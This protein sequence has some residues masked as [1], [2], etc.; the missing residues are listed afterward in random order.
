[1]KVPERNILFPI[2]VVL[3]ILLVTILLGIK[4]STPLGM[5]FV[6]VSTVMLVLAIYYSVEYGNNAVAVLNAMSLLSLLI[7]PIYLLILLPAGLLIM[8]EEVIKEKYYIDLARV[9]LIA[10]MVL[11][12][13]M[14]FFTAP[15]VAFTFP[16]L[17]VLLATILLF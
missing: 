11:T 12:T 16:L 1:M 3:S 10:G 13:F 15:V 14:I 8:S 6:A 7:N 17:L 2:F 9:L 4:L 5:F